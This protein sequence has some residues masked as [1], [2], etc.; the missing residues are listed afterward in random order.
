VKVTLSVARAA[1]GGS[2]AIAVVEDIQERK[3]LEEEARRAAEFEN[4]LYGMMGHDIRSPLAALKATVAAMEVRPEGM[5][6]TQKR[7]LARISRA[8]NRIQRLV[9]E[10]LDYTRLRLNDGDLSVQ[11]RP[12][13][14]HAL[15]EQVVDEFA[16]VHPGRVTLSTADVDGHAL[17]DAERMRQLL[18]NLVE[19]ALTYGSH[20]RPVWL[21]LNGDDE[22]LTLQVH[23]DGEPIPA[24]RLER[25]FEPFNYGP[26]VKQTVKLSLGLG[27]Y[28]VREVVRAHGG[29]VTVRSS[30]EEGTTF[31]VTLPRRPPGWGGRA[32]PLPARDGERHAP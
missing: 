10:L 13:D 29:T 1:Q 2:W 19:N 14:A 17:W 18:E 22:A 25:L 20:D 15:L 4:Q 9:Q 27:L 31:R 7:A 11:P 3:R 6:E 30:K 24:E 12:T 8:T 16:R 28:L 32:V 26:G 21:L 5:S 23:N